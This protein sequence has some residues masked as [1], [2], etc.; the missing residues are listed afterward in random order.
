M[1]YEQYYSLCLC[2]VFAFRR[3]N[4]LVRATSDPKQDMLLSYQLLVPALGKVPKGKVGKSLESL[5]PLAG[6]QFLHLQV[7]MLPYRIEPILLAVIVQL[8]FRKAS[9]YEIFSL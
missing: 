7:L 6:H 5:H 3:N 1:Y 2:H 9:E 4:Y 8:L